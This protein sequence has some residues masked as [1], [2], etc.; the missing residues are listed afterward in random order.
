MSEKIINKLL[1]GRFLL[2]VIVGLVFGYMA[3]RGKMTSEACS[4]IIATVFTAYF[5]RNDRGGKS[6]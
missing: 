6:V 2:T 3:I 4:A 1:S 5:N